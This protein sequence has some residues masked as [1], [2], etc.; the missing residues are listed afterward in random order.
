MGHLGFNGPA[1]PRS[2][3]VQGAR[4]ALVRLFDFALA[5]GVQL[6]AFDASTGLI[7]AFLTAQTAVT[8]PRK[9]LL[10]LRWA[11]KVLKVCQGS[12]E[13]ILDGFKSKARRAPR[14]GVFAG[15]RSS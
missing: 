1:G 12:L 6:E 13:P 10:G 15:Q 5:R 8:M 9:L 3:R 4:R 11:A 7:S 14:H 2:F